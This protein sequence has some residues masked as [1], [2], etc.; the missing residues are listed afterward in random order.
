M[1]LKKL[2]F[3]YLDRGDLLAKLDYEM[4]DAFADCDVERSESNL[5]RA[6]EIEK[7]YAMVEDE[8][9]AD[10]RL[11]AHTKMEIRKDVFSK[12]YVCTNC[13]S[14]YKEGILNCRYCP[15]CGAVIDNRKT[16]GN[17]LKINEF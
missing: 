2:S 9:L 11:N 4:G 13:Y 14:S 16:D 8:P 1:A 17:L 7:I 15:N 3:G 10:V 6:H 5:A 12:Y